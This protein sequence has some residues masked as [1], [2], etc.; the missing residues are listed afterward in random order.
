[1]RV[2]LVFLYLACPCSI[3]S[4]VQTRPEKPIVLPNSFLSGNMIRFLKV[5]KRRLLSE[6][7][8]RPDSV[9]TSSSYFLETD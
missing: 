1:M 7:L 4:L 2:A 6:R 8:K 5:S 9:S 3:A